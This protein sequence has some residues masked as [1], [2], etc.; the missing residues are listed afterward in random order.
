MDLTQ[1]FYDEL[2]PHYDKLFSDW[3]EAS[4]QQ[5]GFLSRLFRAY[6]FDAGARVLDCACGIG[7]Q[8]IGLAALGYDVTAS[9]I[10]E[11]AMTEADRRAN[12]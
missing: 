3:A 6:G 4:G 2:A 8:A 1:T 9:D 11:G 5:A 7:T 12:E 10:S